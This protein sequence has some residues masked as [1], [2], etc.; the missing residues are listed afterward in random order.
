MARTN[1]IGLRREPQP[2]MPR[3]M[4][5]RSSVTTA[6][7]VRRLSAISPLQECLAGVVC[8]R[9]QGMLEGETL[10]EAVAALHVDGVDAVDGLLGQPD[11]VCVLARNLAGPFL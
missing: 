10:L 6:S 5:S 8:P 3:V 11:D 4:P 7:W 9:I 1:D 2:P